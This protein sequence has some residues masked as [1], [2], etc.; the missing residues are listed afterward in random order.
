MKSLAG[1]VIVL[2][3]LAILFFL[4]L[5]NFAINQAINRLNFALRGLINPDFSYESFQEMILA[6]KKLDLVCDS[7]SAKSP[8]KNENNLV[9]VDIY[10]RYP[11]NDR[12]KL[13]IDA[14]SADGL[15]TGFPVLAAE[16]ALLGK[17]IGVEKHLSEVQTIFDPAW[18]SVA[19]IGP[20]KIQ[21]LLS[22]G[23]T[24]VLDLIEPTAEI[25]EGATVINLAPD[26][27]YG[28]LLGRI[29]NFKKTPV[30]PWISGQL[31]P[32][33]DLSKLNRVIVVTDHYLTNESR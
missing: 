15:K 7:D 17:I 24:P 33:Y 8:F 6:Q 10:S 23:R 9:A 18:R 22:G 25:E 29:I 13:V 32:L 28:L 11:F 4:F 30:Q 19:G 21:A 2:L 20:Q 1:F 14:G 26:F 3:I 31:E 12:A 27:P 16:G 5:N